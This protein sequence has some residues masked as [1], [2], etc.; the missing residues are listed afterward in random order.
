MIA[1]V[2]MMRLVLVGAVAALA[3][4]AFASAASTPS[5]EAVPVQPACTF[6]I[7]LPELIQ[8]GGGA[9][10]VTCTFT[11]RG[12]DHTLVVDF[13][14]DLAA[15]PPLTIDGCTLDSNPIHRGPC[16]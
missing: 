13:T 2:R 12:V 11:I 5:A 9:D 10:T 6:A 15:R 14:V 3:F 1:R 16:P 4:F 8:Q 7:P